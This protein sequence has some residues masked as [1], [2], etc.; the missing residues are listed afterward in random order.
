MPDSNVATETAFP[1]GLANQA[2]SSGND[3]SAAWRCEINTFMHG[4]KAA[5]RMFAMAER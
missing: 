2:R 1:T 4:I 3:W 5:N